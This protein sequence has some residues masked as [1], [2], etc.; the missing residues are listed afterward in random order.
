MYYLWRPYTTL[1][2]NILLTPAIYIYMY[3][4]IFTYIFVS[5]FSLTDTDN[6]Q[7][8]RGKEGTIF[9]STSLYHFHPL[10]NIETFICKFAREMAITFF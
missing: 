6:S 4:Y 3:I 8:S 5:R 7:E 2:G 9:Y 1:D 10:T